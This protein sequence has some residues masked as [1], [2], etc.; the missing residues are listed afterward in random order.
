MNIQVDARVKRLTDELGDLN[1]AMQLWCKAKLC[2]D[3]QKNPMSKDWIPGYDLLRNEGLNNL[4]N[5]TIDELQ[6]L[7]EK[8]GFCLRD[9]GE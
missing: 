5:E 2:E 8:W 3:L 4:K 7:C 1:R 6:Q 9:F